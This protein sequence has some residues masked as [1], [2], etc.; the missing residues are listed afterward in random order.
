MIEITEEMTDLK[1]LL[2]S[3][4][5]LIDKLY[6]EGIK[7]NPYEKHKPKEQEI[8]EDGVNE[9]NQLKKHKKRD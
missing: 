1:D 5:Y 7:Q 2:M 4:K 8:P 9:W 3:R 6:E